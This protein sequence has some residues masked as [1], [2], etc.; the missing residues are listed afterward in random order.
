VR[1]QE[2]EARRLSSLRRTGRDELIDDDL[3]AVV[4]VAE[5]RF[6][7]HETLR[8]FRPRT[9]TRTRGTRLREWRLWISNDDFASSRCCSGTYFSFV[10][11]SSSTACRRENVPRSVS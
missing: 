2:R 7:Q 10:R 3:R 4:E 1:Q 6:P 11:A 5:L 8:Q 9:R